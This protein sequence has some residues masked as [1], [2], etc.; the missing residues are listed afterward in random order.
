MG[1]GTRLSYVCPSL[2]SVCTQ[3][4][5]GPQPQCGCNLMNP[6]A[7]AQPPSPWEVQPH[8]GKSPG[9]A[10]LSEDVDTCW[11]PAPGC[12]LGPPRAAPS[13]IV[14]GS[15]EVAFH[16]L[17]CGLRHTQVSP[18]QPLPSRPCPG[19]TSSRSGV[20]SP[21]HCLLLCACMFTRV[22]RLFLAVLVCSTG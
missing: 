13:L 1:I 14:T 6:G 19:F 7:L 21:Q 4:T 15:E 9:C 16:L 22:C 12:L 3:Q 8:P 11:G 17:H 10:Q 2:G 5:R 20:P 18:P